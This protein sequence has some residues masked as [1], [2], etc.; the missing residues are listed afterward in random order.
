LVCSGPTAYE[1]LQPSNQQFDSRVGD[2]PD[3]PVIGKP[4]AKGINVEEFETETLGA[5]NRSALAKRFLKQK[6]S[7]ISLTKPAFP[8]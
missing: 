4:D 8:S 2:F 6:L 7:R 3:L 1:R 5:N